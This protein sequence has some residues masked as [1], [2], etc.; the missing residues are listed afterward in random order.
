M[1]I[2]GILP[3][4]ASEGFNNDTEN[5]D[6]QGNAQGYQIDWEQSIDNGIGHCKDPREIKRKA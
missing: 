6:A 5:T 4:N 3:H 2:D 1:D